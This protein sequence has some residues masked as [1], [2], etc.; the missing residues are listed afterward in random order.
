[1]VIDEGEDKDRIDH[2]PPFRHVNNQQSSLDNHQSIPR[3][4]PQPNPWWRGRGV[5]LQIDFVAE[6]SWINDF[7]LGKK[8]YL[9]SPG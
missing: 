4:L 7:K 1:V 5:G 9:L 3:R 6:D 2:T 8:R